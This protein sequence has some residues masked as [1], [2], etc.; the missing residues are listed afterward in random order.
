VIIIFTNRKLVQAG[1][2]AG[3]ERMF[4]ESQNLKGSSEVRIA[5]AKKDVAS[6]KWSLTQG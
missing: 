6:G 4:G 2:T 3:D 5:L 1:V